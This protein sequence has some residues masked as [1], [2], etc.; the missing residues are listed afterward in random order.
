MQVTVTSL[1]DLTWTHA[2]TKKHTCA[3]IYMYVCQVENSA[4]LRKLLLCH[5]SRVLLYVV[6][7]SFLL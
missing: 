5:M 6:S 1:G 7:E 4:S 2:H 3:A